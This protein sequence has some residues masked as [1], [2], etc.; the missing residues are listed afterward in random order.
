MIIFL[1][2]EDTFR[3]KQKLK[4][5]SHKFTRDIDS[6]SL[7]IA[8]LDGASL[9]VESFKQAI[10]AGGFL[11]RKRMI[12]IEN[13]LEKNK[14]KKIADDIL[15]LLKKKEPDY[16]KHNSNIIIFWERLGQ[17]SFEYKG[18]VLSGKL[19]NYLK[20][21]EYAFEFSFLEKNKLISWTRER[22]KNRGG[23]IRLDAL[24]LLT[25]LVGRNLWKMSNEI[26]K[27]IFYRGG[28]IEI[29]DVKELVKSQFNEKIFKL[30]DAIADQNKKEF[31]KLLNNHMEA[32]IDPSYILSM[33]IRQFR[34]L[35]CALDRINNNPYANLAKDL[36]VPLFVE[37]KL[38]KQARKY[39]MGQLKNIYGKLLAIDVKIKQGYF[40]IEL[41][42][43][44]LL[45]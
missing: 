34:L 5:F 26:D 15:E 3:S 38:K 45:R 14:G 42:F 18:K 1:Y 30:T 19:F 25:D 36:K 8:I 16:N 43:Y 44:D 6:S 39:K 9:D 40:N 12:I 10:Y 11:V 7:N 4:E 13:F 23:N 20:K 22:I 32:G 29:K 33:L 17:K 35:I 37:Q 31:I 2:G 21:G 24:Q 41:L 28:I 27:L